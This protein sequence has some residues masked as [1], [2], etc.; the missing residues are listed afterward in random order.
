MSS[1]LNIN[2]NYN[3][4]TGKLNRH[5]TG[6]DKN[7]KMIP[8][9]SL[10]KILAYKML[11]TNMLND[12]FTFDTSVYL[13]P[14]AK[15]FSIGLGGGTSID[16]VV[17]HIN[18]SGVPS[19]IITDACDS[20]PE[21][22]SL[23][24]MINVAYNTAEYLVYKDKSDNGYQSHYA[25]YYIMDKKKQISMFIDNH[26]LGPGKIHEYRKGKLY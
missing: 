19:V 13:Y 26:F 8:S 7:A 15:I 25:G 20:C 18:K 11:K 16:K 23:A 1:G 2:P 14:K 9:I 5:I 3:S 6:T 24:Y 17:D 4:F 10:A 21:F 12:L 22:S